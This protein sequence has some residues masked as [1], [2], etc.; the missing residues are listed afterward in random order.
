MAVEV[1]RYNFGARDVLGP[2]DDD[3]VSVADG[4]TTALSQDGAY[5]IK[6]ITAC[7]V[8]CKAGISDATGGRSWAAGDREVRYLRSG[9]VI[10][11]D[12]A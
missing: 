1:T 8:R 4:N 10:A 3:T 12:A 9:T 6:A 5:L 11:V 7:T 2:D